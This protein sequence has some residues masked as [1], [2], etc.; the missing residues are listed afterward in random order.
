MDEICHWEDTNKVAIM[1]T[2]NPSNPMIYSDISYRQ[3]SVPPQSGHSSVPG[4]TLVP[5]LRHSTTTF[6]PPP[7]SSRVRTVRTP[8]VL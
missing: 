1:V 2:Q 4:E 5:Q 7:G 8:I 6:D 3:N